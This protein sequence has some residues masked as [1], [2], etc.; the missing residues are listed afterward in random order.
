MIMPIK[1]IHYLVMTVIKED[2]FI[3]YKTDVR[4]LPDHRNG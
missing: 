2:D 3:D 4:D 1:E